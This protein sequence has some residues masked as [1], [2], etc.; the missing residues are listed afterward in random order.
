MSDI[1]HRININAPP[2]R[3]YEAIT[4]AKGLRSWWTDDCAA[5]PVAGSVAEFGFLGKAVVFRM[6]ID[7]LSP[8]RRVAW[9]C[10]GDDREWEGTKLVFDLQATDSGGTDLRFA[11][12]GWR[13]IEGGYARCNCVWGDLM[14]R[15][16][17]H[18][19][20]RLVEPYFKSP[21]PEEE[22]MMEK[23]LR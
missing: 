11:H 23:E 18:A 6:R 5:E 10:L 2:N 22:L 9:T 3:V 4:S 7:E 16:K 20:G 15:L 8:G 1:L 17:A 21:S 14:H 19:E 12:T 13:S